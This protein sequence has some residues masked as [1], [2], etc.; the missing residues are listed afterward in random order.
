MSCE[1]NF[2]PALTTPLLGTRPQRALW[3]GCLP[4]IRCSGAVVTGQASAVMTGEATSPLDGKTIPMH[5][6]ILARDSVDFLRRKLGGDNASSRDMWSKD[7]QAE[8]TARFLL[9]THGVQAMPLG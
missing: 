1:Y 6:Y 3:W 9:S 5:A 8:T 4:G 2:R 7:D